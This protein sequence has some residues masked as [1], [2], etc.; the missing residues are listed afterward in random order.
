MPETVFEKVYQVVK[1]IP[2]GKVSTYGA[3]AKK[4]GL[5]DARVVGWALHV[6]HDSGVPCHRV[7]NREGRLAPNFAFGGWQEQKLR[8]LEEGVGFKKEDKVDLKN[9]LFSF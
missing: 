6:N 7:V 9:C 4:A 5:K 1:K 2:S 3:V 8:L